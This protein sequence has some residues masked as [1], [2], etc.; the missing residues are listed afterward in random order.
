MNRS[1][2]M[3]STT[4]CGYCRR[5]KRQFEENG[6]PYEEVDVDEHRQ[7]GDRIV[8]ATGGYRIVPTVEVA[9]RLL[10]N[11]TVIEVK[12]ALNA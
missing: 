2:T 3:Y 11:P 10:V 12:E 4:W 5:L 7:L 9:G 8:E 1:V 6:I